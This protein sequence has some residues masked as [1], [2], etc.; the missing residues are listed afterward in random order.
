MKP[1]PVITLAG[2]C[3]AASLPA[4]A[5]PTN[6]ALGK[7]ATFNTPPNYWGSTDPDDA[8]QITDGKYSSIGEL[9]Q[10]EN[11]RAIWVQKGT[12]GWFSTMP[13]VITI[14]LGKVQPISGL[15][16]STA[17]G[18]SDVKWPRAIVMAVSDDNKTWYDAGAL[19]QL[20]RKNGL[21]PSEGY[22]NYRY[23]THDLQ[24]KG[25]YVAVG[26]AQL[27]Y[28]F[29]DEIEVYKGDDAWLQKTPTGHRL[30]GLDYWVQQT[31]STALAHQRI[32]L[33]AEEVRKRLKA[34]TL[35]APQKTTLEAELNRSLAAALNTEFRSPDF[36]AILPLTNDHR[37]ILA[38]HGQLLASEKFAPVTVWK[39]HRYQWLPLLAKPETKTA[40][41]LNITMLG[42]QHRSD[43]LLLTN[44]T[45]QPQTAT[46]QLKNAPRGAQSGWLS[47]EAVEW[48]DTAQNIPAAGALLPITPVNGSY[49]VEI[50]AGMTRKVWLTV[51]SSKVG[52]GS[53]VSQ[54]EVNAGGR[55]TT[56]PF[57][58]RV[59][60]T[61][62]KKPRLSLSMWDYTN[63]PKSMGLTP[64]NRDAAMKLLRSHYVDSPWA[65][66]SALPRPVADAFDAQNNLRVGPDFTNFDQWIAQWPDARRYFVF[67][68]VNDTFAG[69]K[70]GTPEFHARVG[71]WAKAIS[72]HVKQLGKQPQQLGLLLVDEPHSDTQDAIIAAWAKAINA[73][74]PELTLFEDPTWERP[75]Q[76][77]IQEAITE[78]D[79]LCFH[80]P[81]FKRAGKPV[82]DYAQSLRKSG[83]ELWSY[84]CTGPIRLYDPQMYFRYQAWHTFAQGGTG[85]A[86]WAFADTG[87][88][89]TSWN[90]YP[91]GNTTYAPVF[92]GKDTVHS[93]L[94]W[95]AVRE[96]MQDFEELSMLQDAINSSRNAAWKQRAQ[97]VLS[98]AVA[99]V[100]GTWN[101][102]RSW[103]QQGDANLT[104]NQLAKVRQMLETK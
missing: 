63:M 32:Q 25:R 12:V 88:T 86:F 82:W 92:V 73:A 64:E 71:N 44:A 19:T 90:E 75:D 69:A 39:Q 96:G 97:R 62:M 66:G 89:A 52:A 31:I 10:V 85:Q 2:L 51:D 101:D 84:Q 98:E 87:G 5:Q 67:C 11:T 54:F 60:A 42:N 81:V 45:T 24:T 61:A 21:P 49:R 43:A 6:L 50:P 36:K 3:I 53:S 15:S 17:A 70:M 35:P 4:Q 46:L 94:H 104:D 27:P 34:S 102:K 80:L 40:P 65:T 23:I 9:Q 22:A 30:D 16:F 56:V 38:H 37:A 55:K 100:T 57:A 7:P 58:L 26:V 20:A 99:A 41:Q 83:K 76:T 91:S 59:A 28:A 72:A 29:V 103:E 13:V 77:K 95:D 14:D 47:V 33:D 78:I 79:I 74:A 18:I 93:S 8:K 48:T 1:F 68:A